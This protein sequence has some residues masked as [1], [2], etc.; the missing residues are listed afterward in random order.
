MENVGENNSAVDKLATLQL[1]NKNILQ[2]NGVRRNRY[3]V[4]QN[5]IR[6]REILNIVAHLRDGIRVLWLARHMVLSI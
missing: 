4:F 2:N 5:G 1:E 3:P 6:K